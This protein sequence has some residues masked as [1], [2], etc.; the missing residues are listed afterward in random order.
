MGM[1]GAIADTDLYSGDVV[2]STQSAVDREQALPGAL[3][4]V[5][6]KLTGLRELPATQVLDDSLM[7]ASNYLVSYHYQSIDQ[8]DPQGNTE[9]QLHLIA[10]FFPEEVDKLVQTGNLPRWPQQRPAVQIWVIVDDGLGRVLQPIEYEYAWQATENAAA[11]R[12]LPIVWPQLDDEEQQLIDTSL[13]W[14][15]FTDYLIEKGAPPDGVAIVAAGRNGPVWNLRWALTSGQNNWNWLNN[16]TQLS[17]AMANGI[18]QLVDNLSQATAIQASDQGQWTH[19]ISVSNLLGAKDY[20]ACLNYLEDLSL[21]TDVEILGAE[22][23]LVNFRLQLNASPQYFSEAI[24][25]GAF[26]RPLDTFSTQNFE[27]LR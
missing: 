1:A 19:D 22:P 4:Q 24:R 12:G 14:G 13:V 27:Y 23:G 8:L 6:Q 16:D 17:S 21:V 25:R 7:A 18:E 9:R 10:R 20:T 11:A 15:G 3:R 2:V 5:L 26:L